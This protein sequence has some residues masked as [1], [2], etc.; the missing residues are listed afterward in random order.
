MCGDVRSMCQVLKENLQPIGIDG[1]RLKVFSHG[2]VPSNWL[3]PLRPDSQG[4]LFFSWSRRRHSSIVWQYSLQLTS[5]R[6][7]FMEASVFRL[8]SARRPYPDAQLFSE[9]FKRTLSTAIHRAANRVDILLP[10]TP[11]GPLPLTAN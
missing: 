7:S 9:D 1:I 2:T 4:Q 6:E 5:A 10:S 3:R 8:K 11:A